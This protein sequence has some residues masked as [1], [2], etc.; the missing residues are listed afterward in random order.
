MGYF[1]VSAYLFQAS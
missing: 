1:V